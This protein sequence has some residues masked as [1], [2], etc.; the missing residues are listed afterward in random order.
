SKIAYPQSRDVGKP[1]LPWSRAGKD[2][3]KRI[4][5]HSLVIVFCLATVVA[6]YGQVAR[7]NNGATPPAAPA[8]PKPLPAPPTNQVAGGYLIQPNDVLSVFVYKY[9]ELSRDRVLV[10]PD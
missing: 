4:V 5:F 3:M 9:P 8:G 7:R 6:T 2:N 1:L 10:L